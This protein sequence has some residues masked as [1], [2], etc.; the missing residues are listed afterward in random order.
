MA[1]RSA[2]EK[3]GTGF[4]Y[5]KYP[6]TH[7]EVFRDNSVHTFIL[8]AAMDGYLKPHAGP[9]AALGHGRGRGVRAHRDLPPTK[10]HTLETDG[11]RG[12]PLL[13]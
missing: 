8:A 13:A 9:D 12:T 2:T 3:L 6:W 7:G 5:P 1:K 4:A 11:G 10:M